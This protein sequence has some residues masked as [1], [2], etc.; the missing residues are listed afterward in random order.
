MVFFR[1]SSIYKSN[2]SKVTKF[3]KSICHQTYICGLGDTK[4]SITRSL[5]SLCCRHR[6]L[7]KYLL[8]SYGFDHWPSFLVTSW[9]SNFEIWVGYI[10]AYCMSRIAHLYII[11]YHMYVI[12]VFKLRNNSDLERMTFT[13]KIIILILYLFWAISRKRLSTISLNFIHIA[14]RSSWLTDQDVTLRALITWILLV[15]VAIAWKL[16]TWP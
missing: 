7:V 2:R 11:K 16:V 9:S 12:S 3:A 1:L 14:G 13:C 4:R 10:S 6:S 15:L 5:D 8:I